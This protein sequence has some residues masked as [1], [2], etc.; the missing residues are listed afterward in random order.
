MSK[1]KTF[2][3]YTAVL[4]LAYLHR[5]GFIGIF[6]LPFLWARN[7]RTY[8]LSMGIGCCIWAAYDIIGY[9]RRWKHIFCSWQSA[10]HKEMTPHHIQW[11]N[12]RKRDT[13]I[14]AFLFAALG[15]TALA[16]AICANTI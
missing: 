3:S 13:F 2:R 9:L 16:F 10:S 7:Q 5:Y 8:L 1:R 11:R 14:P 4:I 12:I 15:I 6:A